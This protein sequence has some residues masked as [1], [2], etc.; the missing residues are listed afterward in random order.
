MG[1][2]VRKT[3]PTQADLARVMGVSRKAVSQYTRRPDWEWGRSG[4]FP[5]RPILAWRDAMLSPNPAD[6]VHD[7]GDP[8]G[9]ASGG[10]LQRIRVGKE[11]ALTRV[12]IERAAN[13]KLDRLVKERQLVSREATEERVARNNNAIRLGLQRIARALRQPLAD[14][15]D[16]EKCEELLLRAFKGLCDH[17]FGVADDNDGDVD[18]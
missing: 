5:V 14:E 10:T 17:A 9:S 1:K 15:E 8:P 4:P 18:D 6:A 7:A 13:L 16:P 3:A 11:A 12:A 2:S